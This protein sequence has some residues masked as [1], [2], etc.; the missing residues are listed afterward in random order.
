[1]MTSHFPLVWLISWFG[2]CF[3]LPEPQIKSI[4]MG[5]IA[6]PLQILPSLCLSVSL[7]IEKDG[8]LCV[9]LCHLTH[10]YNV[11]QVLQDVTLL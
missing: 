1:M 3:G 10:L 5:A 2:A 9:N 7:V 11:C 6:A 8:L 4:H